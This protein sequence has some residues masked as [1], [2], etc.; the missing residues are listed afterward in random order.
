VTLF[1]KVFL[2]NAA[3][4][5]GAAVALAVSPATVSSPLL[6][7]EGAVLVAGLT[8]MVLADWVLLRRAFAPFEELKRM[9]AR[10]DP[11]KPGERVAI[12]PSHAEFD[13]LA[14]AFNEMLGRLE[15]ERRDSAWRASAAEEGERRR[16]ARELHDEIGQRLGALLLELQGLARVAPPTLQPRIEELRENMRA[17]IEHV[18]TVARRLRPE[19][20]DEL[21]LPS[22]LA[23]LTNSISRAGAH[24][25]RRIDPDLPALS[26]DAELVVYRV[27]QEALGNVIR[28]AQ[29]REAS[30]ALTHRDA[31]VELV[32][33]DSGAGFDPATDA[34]GQGIRAMRERALTIGARLEVASAPG[35]GT[36]VLLR[37]PR[38]D[39]R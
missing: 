3:L 17:T 29:T 37:L 39:R 7:I 9:M 16:L 12:S 1:W 6:L 33:A 25:Q 14:Q 35:A 2:V 8:V 15:A 20:L 11:L 13:E 22:A 26:Q 27:A 38:V 10:V 24:V 36:R 21:G 4:M 31:V 23:A 5:A 34:A 19:A 30:L 18:R 32:V 28:H